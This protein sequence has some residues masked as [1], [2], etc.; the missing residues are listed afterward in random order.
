[1]AGPQPVVPNGYDIYL[2]SFFRLNSERHNG[3]GYIGT[4]P[5][6]KIIDYANWLDIDDVGN[7]IDII[8]RIDIA[9]VNKIS[10]QIKKQMQQS[11]K[12]T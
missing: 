3:D 9:Y 5:A 10:E 2:D 1:M 4:I 7:F 8:T 6:M 11:S 12:G